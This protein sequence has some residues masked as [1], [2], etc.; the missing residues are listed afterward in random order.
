MEEPSYRLKK[1]GNSHG[2]E[3]RAMRPYSLLTARGRE[4]VQISNHFGQY[5]LISAIV[6]RR[7]E[8]RRELRE[9]AQHSSKVPRA[10]IGHGFLQEQDRLHGDNLGESSC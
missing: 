6:R 7:L 2:R 9:E 8:A 3:E 1:L 5:V 10:V 4:A